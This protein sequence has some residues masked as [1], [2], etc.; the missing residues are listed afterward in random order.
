MGV[1]LHAVS[2]AWAPQVALTHACCRYALQAIDAQA[3]ADALRERLQE[4]GGAQEW[5]WVQ[6]QRWARLCE[7]P[8]YS[9]A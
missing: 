6:H 3:Q 7:Q 4:V 1:V 5:A 9:A 8:L 2:G